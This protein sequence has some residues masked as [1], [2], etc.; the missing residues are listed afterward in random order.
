MSSR[1]NV[2]TFFLGVFSGIWWRIFQCR[3]DFSRVWTARTK[4]KKKINYVVCLDCG[5]EF[6]Y[7]LEKLQVGKEIR[8]CEL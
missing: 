4:D 2:G 5:K 1:T 3:H 7:D 8:I 6:L